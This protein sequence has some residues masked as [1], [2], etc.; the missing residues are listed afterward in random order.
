MAT[1]GVYVIL[2]DAPSPDHR[3][4]NPTSW[5]T[6]F[7]YMVLVTLMCIAAIWAA[8]SPPVLNRREVARPTLY[9][10]SPVEYFRHKLPLLWSTVLIVVLGIVSLSS[11]FYVNYFRWE[12]ERLTRSVQLTNDA[13]VQ[14]S[15]QV[16]TQVDTL[17]HAVRSFYLR[18]GSL[19]E[20]RHFIETLPFD[21]TTINNIY[22]L[23][24]TGQVLIAQT[25][26]SAVQNLSGC[27]CMVFHQA[28]DVDEIFVGQVEEGAITGRF[29][30]QVSRRIGNP[31]SRLGGV[32]LA[33]VRPE[34]FER[35]YQRLVT[36]T[37]STVTMLGMADQKLRART[38]APSA[39]Q[40]AIPV[41]SHLSKR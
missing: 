7:W 11:L 27:D 19:E 31:D 15:W 34:S 2:V 17:L 13:S 35:Y 29:Q 4:V 23:S 38:P 28:K 8:L 12:E 26:E 30:F 22:L 41:E 32:V 1:R 6:V 18:T 25:P 3:A 37:Q 5:V 24:P 39:D 40:W 21:K 9:Q 16:M 36:S 10:F 20:T 33:T 14:H